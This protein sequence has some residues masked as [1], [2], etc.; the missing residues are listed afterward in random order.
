MNGRRARSR[1]TRSSSGGWT[2]LAAVPDLAPGSIDKRLVYDTR[3][4]GNG[5]GGHVFTDV[6]TPAE[7]AA[8]IEYLKTL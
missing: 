4:L 1:P 6:L 3:I 7:R 2:G 8:I 5:N